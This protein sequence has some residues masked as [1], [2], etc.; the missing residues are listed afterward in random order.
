MLFDHY[1]PLAWSHLLK[2][3]SEEPECG[4]ILAAWPSRYLSITSGDGLY[5][6]DVL[7]KTFGLVLKSGFKVWPKVSAQGSPGYVNLESALFIAWGELDAELVTLLAEL[8]LT[9]VQLPPDL[10]GL[11]DDSVAKLSPS[12]AHSEF[13]VSDLIAGYEQ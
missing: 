11:L 7:A 10:F 4:D 6:Q 13:L 9:L 3:L 2:V 5:W 1:I 8:G 12:S